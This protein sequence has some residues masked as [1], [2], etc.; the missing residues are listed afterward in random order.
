MPTIVAPPDSSEYAE[1]HKGYIAAVGN[2]ADGVAILE[3]QR[4]AIAVLRGLHADQAAHRYAPGKWSVKD[5]VG[6]LN[7]SERVLS[8]RLMRIARG[9]V[10]PLPGFDENLIAAGSNADR[11]EIRDLG[12][13]LAA[14]RASTLA[15]VRSL[16]S[17]AL[18]RRGPVREWTMSARAIVFVIAGHFAHHLNV[19][20]DR[21]GIYCD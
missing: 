4:S 1:F 20:R 3:R 7:D 5:V 13:E 14:V 19:L 18:L 2:E 17:D 11:R 12:D 10:T 6:H 16:D 21:Y 15:L 8:Y 9:D